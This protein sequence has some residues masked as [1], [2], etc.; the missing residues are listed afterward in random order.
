MNI[1]KTVKHLIYKITKLNIS[2]KLPFGIDPYEDLQYRFK[3][4]N[5]NLFFDIG[6]NVGQ[7]V[8]AIRNNF[9]TAK[10]WSFEPAQKTFEML[11]ANTVDKNVTCWQ[12]GFGSQNME[13]EIFINQDNHTEPSNSIFNNQN[14]KINGNQKKEKIKIETLDAFCKKHSINKIDYVKIDTE[15][16]DF[17]V[18]KGSYKFLKAQ[19]I[20]FIEVEVSMN[21]ENTFHVKFENIKEYLES[22]NYRAFGIYDQ[23][24]ERS[25]TPPILRRVNVLFISKNFYNNQ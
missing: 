8:N 1:K 24:H 11:K 4:Y 20:S 18:L 23:V 17:E 21:P 10:I 2:K 13:T 15:G 9:P 12:L 6:A 5:F 3:N 22:F 19:K 14:N 25:T 16:Y 7:T